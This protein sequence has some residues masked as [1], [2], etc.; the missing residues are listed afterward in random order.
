MAHRETTEKLTKYE[1]MDERT[2]KLLRDATEKVRNYTES[3]SSTH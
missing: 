2:E 1:D 3:S